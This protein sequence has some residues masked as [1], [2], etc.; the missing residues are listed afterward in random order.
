MARRNSS[1]LVVNIV[2]DTT[3]LKKGA[4]EANK[5]VKGLTNSL[6]AAIPGAL[7][8][9]GS[10]GAG[11][12]LG[13]LTANIGKHIPKVVEKLGPKMGAAGTAIGSGIGAGIIAG[14]AAA[15]IAGAIAAQIE[16]GTNL[17]EQVIKGKARRAGQEITGDLSGEL[18]RGL[19]RIARDVVA[20]SQEVGLA[21][22]KA[23]QTGFSAE[24]FEEHISKAI[25]SLSRANPFLT[26]AQGAE[27]V[28]GVMQAM[29]LEAHQASEVADHMTF[30]WENAGVSTDL[31][32]QFL[33]KQAGVMADNNITMGHA[34]VLLTTL[35]RH[36]LYVTEALSGVRV[37]FGELNKEGSQLNKMVSSLTGKTFADWI[38]SGRS[39]VDMFVALAQA[40]RDN[41][42]AFSDYGISVESSAVLGKL[43]QDVELIMQIMRELE[44]VSGSA[45][46]GMKIR[47]Q[48]LG[49]LYNWLKI[50]ITSRIN[51]VVV[52]VVEWLASMREEWD[53]FK[54]Y[55]TNNVGPLWEEMKINASYAF[56][57]IKESFRTLWAIAE[58]VW[59]GLG[60]PIFKAIV[61]I[62]GVTTAVLGQT[63]RNWMTVITAFMQLLRGDFADAWRTVM[64]R[65]T[66]IVRTVAGKIQGAFN[67]VITVMELFLLKL[68][69]PI[70]FLID[71]INA[72]IGLGRR[73]GL[74]W[75]PT[76]ERLENISLPR[77]DVIKDPREPAKPGTGHGAGDYSSLTKLA[78]E[79]E[80]ERRTRIDSMHRHGF[81]SDE[82]YYN[83]LK[84]RVE[85]DIGTHGRFSPQH[86]QA[87]EDLKALEDRITVDRDVV[88]RE[89][90]QQDTERRR[91]VMDQRRIEDQ[92]HQVGQLSDEEYG[93]ILRKRVIEDRKLFGE[94]SPEHGTSYL[95]SWTFWGKLLKENIPEYEPPKPERETPTGPVID[96]EA[97]KRR[98]EDFMHK[99]GYISDQ[100]YW[101]ILLN[102]HRSD[103]AEY[104]EF[105]P[106]HRVSL[107]AFVRFREAQ[108][109]AER[110]R[111]RKIREAERVHKE[112]EKAEIKAEVDM[113]ED[114][115][116]RKREAEDIRYARYGAEAPWN[117]GAI[118]PKEYLAILNRRYDVDRARY[119]D[120]SREAQKTWLIIQ[121]LLEIIATNTDPE[122]VKK[123]FA[124][125]NIAASTIGFDRQYLGGRPTADTVAIKSNRIGPDEL[126]GLARVSNG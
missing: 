22:L 37:T 12:F 56:D 18:Q 23:I 83:A 122:T 123:A 125:I 91:L 53:G 121:K 105:S 95:A 10:Y 63:F 101:D 89:R 77:I 124:T 98:K 60:E 58:G 35:A 115:L 11:A 2:G 21:A 54:A 24:E 49:D 6:S 72:L 51:E 111:R 88:E 65:I 28:I 126:V 40:M 104:G 34:N 4:D 67:L 112:E 119:G 25:G 30:A 55:V 87:L 50:Q 86:F 29:N 15:G 97:E 82:R 44:Q 31:M 61:F 47:I 7:S 13:S 80:E 27:H 1:D 117:E 103:M 75:L 20:P 108:W 92:K 52:K 85:R 69:D 114:E 110:E 38:N 81:I 84:A 59:K 32:S 26:F 94:W 19:S 57:A 17:I 70:N 90:D 36:G 3:R 99:H 106:E 43:V 9:A 107:D 8:T 64:D 5:I 46:E 73:V 100:R 74:G 66:G 79:T 78:G 68:K 71:K 96:L 109:A 16:E 48:G 45:V 33:R 113:S 39:V 41:E 120:Y 102:R 76:I 14:V 62:L 42:V 93:E 116:R 118:S